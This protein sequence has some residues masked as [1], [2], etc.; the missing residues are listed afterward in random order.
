MYNTFIKDKLIFYGR[1]S[2]GVG[3]KIAI[4]D[5]IKTDAES[6]HRLIRQYEAEKNIDTDCC[7]FN[8]YE[9]M[10]RSDTDFDVFILDYNMPG[11]NGME[12]ARFL[13]EKYSD[14]KTVIFVTSFPEI[15][16]DA[17]EV[18]THRFLLKPV[19]KHKLYEAL[20][21]CMKASAVNKKQ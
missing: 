21:S 11:M 18:R 14:S 20:D 2:G 15:V 19:V 17:F 6:V 13:R 7:V 12:F 5:D 1:S 8:T 10:L 16:Y 9:E 4:C 3:L